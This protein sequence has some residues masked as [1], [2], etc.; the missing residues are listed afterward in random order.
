MKIT[1]PCAFLVKNQEELDTLMKLITDD[2]VWDYLP[3]EH[4]YQYYVELLEE[5][6]D[7]KAEVVYL[8]VIRFWFK[9][10]ELFFGSEQDF[11]DDTLPLVEWRT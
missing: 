10:W 1:Q 3:K 9:N 6:E 7:I 2:N 4:S 5:I 11:K 8:F